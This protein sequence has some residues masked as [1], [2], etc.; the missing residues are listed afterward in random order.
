M[1]GLLNEDIEIHL[2]VCATGEWGMPR[3][4]YVMY[5]YI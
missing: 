4:S 3:F 2:L 1:G 5:I